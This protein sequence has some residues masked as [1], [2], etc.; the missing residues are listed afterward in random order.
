MG[1]VTSFHPPNTY[2]VLHVS[3]RSGNLQ[4]KGEVKGQH[5]EMLTGFMFLDSG[6]YP[7]KELEILKVNFSKCTVSA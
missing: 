6:N 7:G 4:S 5:F 3:E 1:K 2:S